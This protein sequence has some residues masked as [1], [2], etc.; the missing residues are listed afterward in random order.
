L[1]QALV[2]RLSESKPFWRKKP[3]KQAAQA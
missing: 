2:S 3:A 1:L